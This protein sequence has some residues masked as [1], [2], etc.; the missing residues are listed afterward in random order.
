MKRTPLCILVSGLA[1]LLLASCVVEVPSN[2]PSGGTATQLPG[3]A[4]GFSQP[5]TA[6]TGPGSV[7]IREGSRTLTSFRTAKPNVEQT[8]WFSEQEQIVV[9]S[10]GS[11][12]PAAVQLFDSRTGRQLGQ[13][14]H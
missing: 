8:R 2:G 11:H 9:K 14:F 1:T 3:S 7:T 12:G 6:V 13:G 10:R 4:P 5:L